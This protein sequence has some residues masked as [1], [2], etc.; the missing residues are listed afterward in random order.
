MC[1]WW[2]SLI[3]CSINWAAGDLS[4]AKLKYAVVRNIPKALLTHPLALAVGH[5]FC[6]RKVSLENFESKNCDRV[7]WFHCCKASET[8]ATIAESNSLENEQE[9]QVGT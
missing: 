3:S 8:L 7:V 9:I 6:A 2:A 1:Q 5:A 4:Q